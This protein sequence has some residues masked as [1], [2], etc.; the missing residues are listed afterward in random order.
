MAHNN[1][2]APYVNVTEPQPQVQNGAVAESPCDTTQTEPS[3]TKKADPPPAGST[4]HWIEDT[5][6]QKFKD[7]KGSAR[8]S[9]DKISTLR[10]VNLNK[11]LKQTVWRKLQAMKVPNIK[12][13]NYGELMA[14]LEVQKQ[15]LIDM[16]KKNRKRWEFP[17]AVGEIPVHTCFLFALPRKICQDIVEALYLPGE[18]DNKSHPDLNTPYQ[19]DLTFWKCR[20]IL[21]KDEPEDDGGL[22]TG[23]TCLH[24]AIVKVCV[25]VCMY[26][27]LV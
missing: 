5:E 4:Y 21:G 11:Q 14:K 8:S 24:M 2:I 13:E 9:K 25:Y 26:S 22:Y 20:D 12:D 15:E 16:I 7:D 1:K 27:G 10:A 17:G 6:V 23:E 18:E 3:E 19:S